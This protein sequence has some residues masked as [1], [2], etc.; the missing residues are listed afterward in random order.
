MIACNTAK[1]EWQATCIALYIRDKV[2]FKLGQEI[3]VSI[4][5]FKLRENFRKIF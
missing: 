5:P 2:S 1:L 3:F 4:Q